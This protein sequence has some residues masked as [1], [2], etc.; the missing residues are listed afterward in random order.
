MGG[1]Q[2]AGCYARLKGF[3]G[4]KG[5]KKIGAIGKQIARHGW[6]RSTREFA[7]GV[8]FKQRA[9]TGQG[10]NPA[11]QGRNGTNEKDI[12]KS[13]LNLRFRSPGEKRAMEKPR[14]GGG[15]PSQSYWDGAG[16]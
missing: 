9:L 1:G 8:T 3:S 16:G 14:E 4:S 10:E 15:P 7:G 12:R 13:A 11:T 2:I 6:R 5:K